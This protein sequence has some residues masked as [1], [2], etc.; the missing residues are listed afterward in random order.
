[1]K[2]QEAAFRSH[3]KPKKAKEE[4]VVQTPAKP[5]GVKKNRARNERRKAARKTASLLR[6]QKGKVDEAE[7][8][9]S[10]SGEGEG[11][12]EEVKES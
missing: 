9:S 8:V 1:M 3:L 6:A 11:E 7:G 4:A 2:S 10:V 12:A 5:A